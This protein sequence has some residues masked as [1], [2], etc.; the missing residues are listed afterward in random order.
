MVVL[1]RRPELRP[2]QFPPPREYPWT[3][4]Q[5]TELGKI[6]TDYPTELSSRGLRRALSWDAIVEVFF[7]S[8]AGMQ[9]KMRG[10]VR[11]AQLPTRAFL[12]SP[13]SSARGGRPSRK[14]FFRGEYEE[15]I[16]LV[17]LHEIVLIKHFVA[18][19]IRLANHHLA[20]HSVILAIAITV[21]NSYLRVRM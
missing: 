5:D 18:R 21:D 4:S 16:H 11:K 9:W 7:I 2:A 19:L 14:L 12:N 13:T 15:I 17:A 1:F 6:S 10:R 20:A 3:L 8:A